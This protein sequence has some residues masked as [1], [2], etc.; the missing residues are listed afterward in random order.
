[1]FTFIYLLCDLGA[2][3]T[4]ALSLLYYFINEHEV[5]M[6]ATSINLNYVWFVSTFNLSL[7][8]RVREDE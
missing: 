8:S 2:Y 1:M 6:L 7:F 3:L 4:V 5:L